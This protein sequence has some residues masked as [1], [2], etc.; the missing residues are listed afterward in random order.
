VP[1]TPPPPTPTGGPDPDT[2]GSRPER[3]YL[4]TI[5]DSVRMSTWLPALDAYPMMLHATGADGRVTW[6][7]RIRAADAAGFLEA[8]ERLGVTVEEIVGAGVHE[9]YEL[10]VGEPGTGVLSAEELDEAA[11]DLVIE[12]SGYAADAEPADLVEALRAELEGP[13]PDGGERP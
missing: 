11:E 2:D 6:A 10:R 4:L 1:T 13:A 9:A 5:P 3:R 7:T 12:V 8:A